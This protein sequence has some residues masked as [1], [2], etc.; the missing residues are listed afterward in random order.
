MSRV[1]LESKPLGET[2]TE[3]FNF[4]GRL[5]AGETISSAP[6]VASVYSGVDPNP[7]AII[8]GVATISGSTIS[9]KFTGGVLGVIYKVVVTAATSTGQT[10][11]QVGLLAVV[12]DIA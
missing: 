1:V 8:F 11:Q 2:R 4:L 3:A 7:A 10:L 12:P 5:A 9:V 6:I